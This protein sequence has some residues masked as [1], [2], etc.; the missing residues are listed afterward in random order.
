[1][2]DI[3]KKAKKYAEEIFDEESLRF[4]VDIVAKYCQVLGTKLNA[5]TEILMI[6]AYLHDIGRC[7]NE[8]VDHEK[9]SV[10]KT[11]EFLEKE[12]YPKGKIQAVKNC[13]LNHTNKTK[14]E[15]RINIEEKI[16]ANAD[17][18]AHIEAWYMI[19]LVPFRYRGMDYKQGFRWFKRKMEYE[20]NEKLSLPAARELVKDKFEKL[21]F[22]LN[23]F[24]NNFNF[25]NEK[26]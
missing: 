1:M 12:G 6:C 8:N 26:K 10:V 22:L 21:I 9:V 4:H 11:T 7:F 23:Y 20:F 25:A 16:L 3:V 13:I 15:Q 24:D 5:D 18:L 19:L 14:D 17:V 2:K